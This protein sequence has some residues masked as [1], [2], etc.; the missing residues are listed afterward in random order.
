ML[1]IYEGSVENEGP[2]IKLK[3]VSIMSVCLRRDSET[4]KGSIK[5]M[6]IK[7]APLNY[8]KG[9]VFFIL[10]HVYKEYPCL[11]ISKGN[12]LQSRT[13]DKLKNICMTIFS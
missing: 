1:I 5:Q 6:T 10:L 11:F 12:I 3:I 7:I 9:I 4:A 2:A 13:A 8:S